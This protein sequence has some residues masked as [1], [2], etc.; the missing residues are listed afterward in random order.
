[1][2][3]PF[4]RLKRGDGGRFPVHA[5][6]WFLK[7][8]LNWSLE[9][10]FSLGLSPRFKRSFE[11]GDL[12]DYCGL[13]FELEGLIAGRYRPA[14][15]NASG[16]KGFSSVIWSRLPSRHSVAPRWNVWPRGRQRARER[17]TMGGWL[18]STDEIPPRSSSA[19]SMRARIATERN[20]NSHLLSIFLP[21]LEK[22]G[23]LPS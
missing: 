13:H 20:G 6:S 16:A 12:A 4:D 19:G 18:V 10:G 21:T 9:P 11:F 7:A 2:H 22:S 3:W 1:M 14:P 8:M 5:W 23:S 15:G 17:T